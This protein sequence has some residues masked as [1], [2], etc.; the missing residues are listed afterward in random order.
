ME[1][2]SSARDAGALR[3]GLARLYQAEPR[4]RERLLRDLIRDDAVWDVAHPVNRLT[5]IEAIRQGFLE[6]LCGAIENLRRRDDIFIS[7]INRRQAG[8]YWVAST[9]HYVGNFTAPLFGIRPSDRLVFLRSG[10]FYRLVGGKIA[11]A[12]LIIDLPDLMRQA[13]CNPLPG[14]LGTEMLYPAPATH[15]GILPGQAEA[16]SR[17]LDIVE[18]MFADLHEFDPVDFSS[19]R[20]TGSDGCWHSDM[21]WYG[22]GG[23]GSNYRW[24]GFVKDHRKS[25][26]E[27]FPDR[28]G[29]NHYCRL[30]DGNYAAVSGWPSMTMTHQGDYLGIAATGRQLA[31]RVMDFYRCEDARII[32]NWVYLDYGDLLRQMGV[33]LFPA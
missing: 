31:L 3:Q 32:E 26:L 21:L 5:G 11:E 14:E 6:P 30:G 16:G 15:D 20:Q 25:F 2:S 22:P 9:A 8:G 17:T 7:G 1:T 28:A 29:G 18:G 27:A 19:A 10:E 13:G 4:E 24:S 33:D 12:K 23:V